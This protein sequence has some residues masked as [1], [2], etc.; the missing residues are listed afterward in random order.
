MVYISLPVISTFS[1]KERDILFDPRR[2]VVSN[3]RPV[4]SDVLPG[5]IQFS[6]ILLICI[7]NWAG[8]YFYT[9]WS[10]IE[11]TTSKEL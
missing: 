7:L 2:Y 6:L 9:T 1:L 11:P 5:K 8:V 3:T 10:G 4:I